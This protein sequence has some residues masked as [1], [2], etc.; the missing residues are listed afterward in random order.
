MVEEQRQRVEQ[1][2]TKMINEL[3]VD[4]LR[5]MQ[6]AMHKC[7]AACCEN[8]SASLESVQKC[9]ESCSV[10][11]TWAQGYVQRELEQLQN[12]LQRCVMDCNDEVRVKMGPNP[13]HSEVNLLTGL[14]YIK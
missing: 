8:N 12:K 13:T 2:M 9:V 11:L 1:E 3:D 7:A 5:K 10:K 14:I 4:Y 6:A